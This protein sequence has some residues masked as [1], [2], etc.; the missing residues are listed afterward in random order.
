MYSDNLIIFDVHFGELYG[1]FKRDTFLQMEGE[2]KSAESS[3]IAGF[4][5]VEVFAARAST[6]SL[7]VVRPSHP[8]LSNEAKHVF[9]AVVL[10]QRG[11]FFQLNAIILGI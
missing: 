8:H 9:I 11:S 6:L 3:E 2:G 5:F 7:Y 10:V 4:I 1:L